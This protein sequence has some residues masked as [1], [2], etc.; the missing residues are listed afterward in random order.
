[1][2]SEVSSAICTPET[3][4]PGEGA[5]DEINIFRHDIADRALALK[6]KLRKI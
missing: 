5:C 1:M 2:A 4:A 3:C 6:V